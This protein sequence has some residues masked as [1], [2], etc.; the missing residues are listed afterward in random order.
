MVYGIALP[1]FVDFQ[2]KKHQQQIQGKKKSQNQSAGY[3]DGGAP[4][5]SD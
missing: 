2:E 5:A 4:L 1:T 3:T